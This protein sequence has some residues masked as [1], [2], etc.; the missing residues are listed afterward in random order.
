M[1]IV[2]LITKVLTFPG[3]YFKGF[4]EHL[5]CRMLKI[6]VTNGSYLRGNN[7][8]GHAQHELP[9]CPKKA[10]LVAFLPWAAQKLLALIFLCASAIPLFLF[11]LR[12]MRETGFFYV[13]ILFLYV[14]VSFLCNAY[15][16]GMDARNLW[17]LFYRVKE[18]PAFAARLLL[19]PFNAALC[20]F[21]LLERTGA[22]FLLW[23]GLAA[24]G[25]VLTR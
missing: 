15:P 16:H 12:G 2:Y 10:F 9:A 8:C 23:V 3:A 24:A 4:W 22:S 20:F 1:S 18:R 6:P 5:T 17:R 13:E 21:S 7:W 19:A 14:G 11:G 25:F